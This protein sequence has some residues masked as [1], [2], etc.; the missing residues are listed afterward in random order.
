MSWVEIFLNFHKWGGGD[1]YQRPE[2][3][4][5]EKLLDVHLASG[6]SFDCN[7]SE[8]CK[9]ASRKVR[10]LARGTSGISLSKRCTLMNAFFKSQ[11]NYCRLIWMCHSCEDNNKINRLHERCLRFLY[12]DKRSLFKTLLENDSSFSIHENSIKILA[13]KMFEVS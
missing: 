7:T 5:R 8:I 4:K 10:A 2:S 1:V 9:K 11:F 13:A 3:T 12:N 6:L